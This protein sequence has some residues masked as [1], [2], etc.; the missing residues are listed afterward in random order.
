M[1]YQQLPE[2][3]FA[4]ILAANGFPQE[5]ADSI[6]DADRDSPE[7]SGSPTAATCGA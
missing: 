6:A 5:F 2:R 7:A 4:Q 1:R 3:D